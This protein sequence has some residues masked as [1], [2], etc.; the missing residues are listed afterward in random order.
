MESQKEEIKNKLDIVEVIGEYL[1]LQKSG[2]N[3]QA[4]CPFHKEKTPSFFVSPSRQ[5][6]HC[7]GCNTGG[8]IFTFVMKIENIDFREAL[9]ILAKKAGIKLTYENPQAR[10][11]KQKLININKEAAIFFEN[12]LWR[13][14][15]VIEYLHQRGL[16]DE[17]IREFHLGWALDDWRSLS[18]YLIKKGFK[19][20]EII[21]SGLAINRREI[22]EINA[23]PQAES[24]K[25]KD[26]D[27][28]DRFRS[29]IIFPLEDQSGN[30]VG[31]TARIF[32]GKNPLKTIKDIERVGKYINTP[33]TEIFDKGKVLY[34]LSRTKKNLHME[35][36]IIVVEGQMDFLALWQ[37]GIR[38]AVAT[39]GTALT[40]YHLALLKKYNDNLILGFDMD[41]AGEKAAEKTIGL[42]LF[43]GFNVKIL[44]LPEGKDLAEYLLTDQGKNSIKE[45]IKKSEPIMSFYFER[46]KKHSDKKTVEG[47]KTIAAFFLSKIKKLNNALEK[48]FWL[49]KLSRYLEIPLAALE[50]ELKKIS[51]NN[52]AYGYNDENEDNLKVINDFLAPF[53]SRAEKIADRLLAFFVKF[54]K[55]FELAINYLKYFPSSFQNI[56]EILKSVSSEKDLAEE[57]L[58]K[59]NI[60]DEIINKISLLNLK[61]D[62]EIEILDKFNVNID[63]ELKKGLIE[64]KQEVLKKE[65][66]AIGFQIKNLEKSRDN[67][68]IKELLEKFTQLS[69]ELIK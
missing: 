53:E 57:N 52:E 4:L 38:N 46:A 62:Y 29:R 66:E 50:E 27:L 61:A 22:A 10:S 45:L 20:E 59:L 47:K 54:P 18:N 6:W 65:M 28:Y 37:E 9:E 23:K 7:F 63:E 2:T 43:K 48:A 36:A 56:I 16:K 24:C 11:Q 17:T 19:P 51:L 8:D 60:S 49:E 42:V 14:K 30:F 3:Y 41:E 32:Q 35:E 33:Q 67:K 13:N 12:N 26:T 34:G 44:R 69:K 68:K 64:L 39:S 1:K 40:S 55:K 5:I 15:E 31:F 21:A 25:L 58:K